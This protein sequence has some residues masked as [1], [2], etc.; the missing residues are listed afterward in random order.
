MRCRAEVRCLRRTVKRCQL[1]HRYG[2]ISLPDG[3]SHYLAKPGRR[4]V[5]GCA[6]S[7]VVYGLRALA[8]FVRLFRLFNALQPDYLPLESNPVTLTV[9]CLIESCSDCGVYDP[10]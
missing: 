6:L 5:K 10:S 2:H 1:L 8:V 9:I 7:Q 3:V 4:E